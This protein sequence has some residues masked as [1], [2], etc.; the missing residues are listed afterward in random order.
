MS[1]QKMGHR[2]NQKSP[3]ARSHLLSLSTVCVDSTTW[4]PATLPVVVC[5]YQPTKIW[6]IG[7]LARTR[8][9][10]RLEARFFHCW[11]RG[12][13]TKS[14]GSDSTN[15]SVCPTTCSV[16]VLESL[17]PQQ[18]HNET[19]LWVQSCAWTSGCRR[20]LRRCSLGQ[21]THLHSFAPTGAW[22]AP[23]SNWDTILL[24]NLVRT[25]YSSRVVC[26]QIHTCLPT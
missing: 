16:V 8:H 1:T 12:C 13:T 4:T 19:S 14:P 22:T 3:A 26:T 11:A 5:A 18:A 6:P 15:C 23:A 9:R 2:R 24:Y 7:R 10:S 25:V 20:G 17:L 21:F